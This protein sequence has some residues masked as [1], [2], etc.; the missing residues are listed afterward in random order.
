MQMTAIYI[1][2]I[3]TQIELMTFD[4]R[5]FMALLSISLVEMLI[6][7]KIT[8]QKQQSKIHFD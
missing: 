8:E 3:E 2:Q 6:D 7:R 1:A 4:K 5:H